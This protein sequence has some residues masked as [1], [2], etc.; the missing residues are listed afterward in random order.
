MDEERYKRVAKE[1]KALFER[2][3]GGLSFEDLHRVGG[4]PINK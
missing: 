3:F 4:H 2:E 1:I